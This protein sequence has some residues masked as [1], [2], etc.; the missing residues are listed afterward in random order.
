VDVELQRFKERIDAEKQ[1]TDHLRAE[2]MDVTWRENTLKQGEAAYLN[3]WNACYVAHDYA[4]AEKFLQDSAHFL[5]L[6]GK[7]LPV[8]M[9]FITIALIIIGV[10]LFLLAKR[11]GFIT[12]GNGSSK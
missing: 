11:F 10:I 1:L 12:L 5:P 2:G 3:A 9:V 4:S 8:S 6:P 7:E